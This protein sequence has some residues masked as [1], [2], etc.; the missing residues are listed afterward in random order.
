MHIY[1]TW[2]LWSRKPH[3]PRRDRLSRTHAIGSRISV[4]RLVCFAYLQLPLS[5]PVTM[6]YCLAE[7]WPLHALIYE[8]FAQ[9]S[10]VWSNGLQVLKC[11]MPHLRTLSQFHLI[12]VRAR[13]YESSVTKLY[14]ISKALPEYV[15]LP[16]HCAYFREKQK[17]RCRSAC[18]HD[19]PQQLIK[20]LFL[21]PHLV[22]LEM[23]GSF[24]PPLAGTNHEV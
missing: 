15:V 12:A 2:V 20:K 1:T 19:N 16:M 3:S 9:K 6:Q 14:W 21:Q 10:Q 5:V 18:S 11:S 4:Y 7:P 24:Y 8:E 23:Q 13:D 22:P 17:W